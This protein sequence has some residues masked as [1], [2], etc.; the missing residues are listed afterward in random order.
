VI[1]ALLIALLAGGGGRSALRQKTGSADTGRGSTLVQAAAGYLRITPA[2]LRARLRS[3]ETLAQV[4]AKTKG[5]SRAGLI[6]TAYASKARAIRARHLP[7]AQESA[8]LAALRRQLSSQVDQG[9]KLR[10]IPAVARRYLGIDEAQLSRELAGGRTLGELAAVTPGRSR[11]GLIEALLATRVKALQR[12]LAER[13]LTA[14]AE[15]RAA[16]ALR[17]R[18][19]RL[20]DRP[21]G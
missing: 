4:A 13:R 12:A 16:A 7:P 1:A 2:Q 5:A 19:R 3:G 8:E 17:R 11:A 6:A 10:R 18:V 21:G 20:V 14:A 9:R 15:R